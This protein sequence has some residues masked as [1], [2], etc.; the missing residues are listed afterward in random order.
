VKI[1]LPEAVRKI[2]QTLSANGFEAYAVGGCVR[3][4]LLKQTPSDW[5]ITTSCPPEKIKDLFKK[6]IDTGLKHGTVSVLLEN[7]VYEVTT[8]RLDGDYKDG[9]HPSSVSFTHSL[10]EDLARRDF[11]INAMAYN[12][13]KGL[14]DPFDG[15]GDLQNKIIR[16]VGTPDTRFLEDALRML[17][18]VR[19]AA[20]KG[21]SIEEQTLSSIQKNAAL[22][23]KL[24]AERIISEITKILLS[25]DVFK[26]KTLYY[27]GL[28]AY[29]MPEMVHCFETQQNIKWHLYDVGTHSLFAV[30]FVEKKPYLLYSALM[31]DWGKPLTKGTNPDGSD[32]FRNHA[33]E[34][35]R[36]AEDFMNRYKFSN[37]D[38][39][40]IL[41]LVKNHD[42]EILPD[43][44]YVKRAVSA[45]GD[46]IFTDLLNLK[47]ADAKA[48][49]FSLT[50]PRLA[51]Y[52]TLEKIYV[53]FKENDEVFSLKQ[54][55]VNGHDL[56]ALGFCG[57][58]IGVILDQLLQHVIEHP[59]ENKKELLLTKIKAPL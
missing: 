47:R 21:F 11:T 38:K 13:T 19:F 59:E 24:S 32:S 58:E 28:L 37:K 4:S 52:D 45:V 48:Q 34:S 41:R 51:H 29:I 2:I 10:E 8:F 49:N 31:H 27:T 22:V 30:S 26:I 44:K 1:V 46:D 23:K 55:S 6:T 56:K 18:A 39:D 57:K 3:D 9:R 12:E 36:L 15:L 20:Q 14:I 43:K 5:D 42:R 40:K 17:R 54:L 50:A 53:S 25:D 35:V 7:E 33:K 16:C